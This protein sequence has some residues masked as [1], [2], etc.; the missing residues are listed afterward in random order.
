MLHQF[1]LKAEAARRISEDA[2]QALYEICSDV[3][4]VEARRDLI[5]EGQSGS[6]AVLIVAGWAASFNILPD[7]SRQFSAFHIPG[8]V[9]NGKM[10]VR[11]LEYG[12][13]ALT[14]CKAAL[15]PHA[16]LHDALGRHR[17]L[18]EAFARANMATDSTLRAWIVNIGRREGH[19]RIAH[20]IC[21]LHVRLN[22][23]GLV[24]TRR[25]GGVE[26][27]FPVTQEELA[28]AVGLTPVHTN[29]VLQRLRAEE[30][31]D[32]RHRRVVI[33]DPE[34]L[35]RVAGFDPAHLQL[36][37]APLQIS[38][39]EYVSDGKPLWNWGAAQS[40]PAPSLPA[41]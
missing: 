22:A 21:E 12:L 3:R 5:F 9:C 40:R 20:L 34:A 35:C 10:S 17:D 27:E 25:D 30:L 33:H 38:S 29:R 1:F 37:S 7:G 4:T 41:W 28:D 2:K 32:L 36:P 11:S 15:I 26:F 31:M 8:D 19:E 16:S 24:E 13:V 6:H 18:A 39:P 23:A 14:A